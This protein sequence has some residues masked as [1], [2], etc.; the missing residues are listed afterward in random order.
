MKKLFAIFGIF[1]LF[2][3]G[4]NAY[5]PS[6]SDLEKINETKKALDEVVDDN[7]D[8][9]KL[10]HQFAVLEDEYSNNEQLTAILST[11][12][13]YL[14]D[15]L[16]EEK[17]ENK[18]SSQEFRKSFLTLEIE[19]NNELDEYLDDVQVLNQCLK[20]YELVD[21][22]SFAYD[23]PTELAIA[24]RY[25]ETTCGMYLPNNGYG[26]FQIISNDYGTGDLGENE[27]VEA[28]VDFIEFS[29][30]KRNSYSNKV[31]LDIPYDGFSRQ[32]II[33]HLA[34]YN[35]WYIESGVVIPNKPGYLFDNYN[36]EYAWATKDWVYT[37]F[38]K[39]MRD[40]EELTNKE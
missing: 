28:L 2:W 12:R 29:N 39:L 31:D 4:I 10:A 32:A 7:K 21:D 17:E 16:D 27:F 24:T 19:H 33:N 11:L 23:F 26:P 6:M 1:L 5:I 34:L 8:I 22:V 37:L 40:A 30:W 36:E 9:W 20:Y 15:R 14:D 38:L 25:R 3:V 35:W 18:K 13:T